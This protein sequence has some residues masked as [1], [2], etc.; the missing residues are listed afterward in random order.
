M[1]QINFTFLLKQKKKKKNP[2][3]LGGYL[4]TMEIFYFFTPIMLVSF[5]FFFFKYLNNYRVCFL[6]DN[7]FKYLKLKNKNGDEID[8]CRK[9]DSVFV[10]KDIG[11]IND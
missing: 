9:R 2:Q 8:F 10:W 11:W 1:M 5:F 6:A 4:K 7:W 3:A